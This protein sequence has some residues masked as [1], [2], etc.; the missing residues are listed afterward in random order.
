MPTLK[1]RN[2]YISH[3]PDVYHEICEVFT[4]AKLTNKIHDFVMLDVNG[5]TPFPIDPNIAVKELKIK[6]LI[7]K[8]LDSKT[9][10]IKIELG[11]WESA[12]CPIYTDNITKDDLEKAERE[13]Y[14]IMCHYYR[15][16]SDDVN[17]LLKGIG[18]S[19]EIE[20]FKD[21]VCKEEETLVMNYGGVYYEDMSEEEY[22]AII[23]NDDAEHCK[24]IT[25]CE[26]IASKNNE[27]KD[28]F[29]E[30]STIIELRESRGASTIFNEKY[31]IKSA[32][33]EKCKEYLDEIKKIVFV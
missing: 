13:L 23:E 8:W 30:L 22:N 32:D 10:V 33:L 15:W 3:K 25:L 2:L 20:E 1:Y 5:G 27:L 29:T 19:R 9:D 14:D 12:P 6:K 17:R 11:A 18:D 28:L 4:D 7:D 16:N 21:A 24:I 31:E 26:S